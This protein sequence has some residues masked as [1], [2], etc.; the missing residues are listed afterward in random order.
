VQGEDGGPVYCIRATPSVESL[1]VSRKPFASYVDD[2]GV[3]GDVNVGRVVNDKTSNTVAGEAERVPYSAVAR[4]MICDLR[5]AKSW[6]SATR[7]CVCCISCVVDMV[8]G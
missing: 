3:F 6:C 8:V 4:L 5:A 7:A 1:S 2:G